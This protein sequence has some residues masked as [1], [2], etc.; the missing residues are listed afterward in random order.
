MT[1][2]GSKKSEIRNQESKK[3]ITRCLLPVV[4][5]LFTI[6]YSLF[7]ASDAYAGEPTLQVKQTVDKVLEILRNEELKKPEK[8]TE[9]R[10]AIR[11]VIDERFDFE[12]MAKRSLALHWKDR[13]PAERKEFIPLYADLLERAYIKKIENYTDEDVLYIGESINNEHAIVKTKVITKR[14]VEIPIDYRLLRKDG[15][16]EAYDVLI[17]GV[18]LVSNYRTQFNK[19]IR[20][21]SYEELIRRLKN[22]QEEELFEEKK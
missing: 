19:I 10:S 7:A 17:E 21:Q 13:T 11:K 6:H 15:K 12:E 22:K 1:E 2:N 20:T 16:W 8:T 18:S 3:L 4:L 9:R 14:K 5:L